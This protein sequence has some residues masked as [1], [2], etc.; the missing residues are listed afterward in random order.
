MARSHWLNALLTV[1][2]VAVYVFMLAPVLVVI[3]LAFNEAEYG[4]FPITGLTLRWF[5]ELWRDAAI[6]EALKTS[7][8]LGAGAA[9]LSTILGTAAAYAIA[10]F[11]FP[12]RALVQVF[13]T[14]PLLV[15]HLILGVGLLLAFRM[16]GLPRSFIL[17][18]AGHVALTLP[19]VVLTT[20]HR[21][22]KIPIAV[23]EAAMTLGASRLKTF[24]QITLPLAAPAIISG[25]LLA[26]ITSFDEVT[27][28]LF[29]RPSG[30][31]TVP[32]Q[33]MA[34]LQYSI[35]QRLNALGAVMTALS[36]G[37]PLALVLLF[38]ALPGSGRAS[39]KE[40]DQ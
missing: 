17:L 21:F 23:E 13:L 9:V 29:W 34:M 14:L 30:I 28:T 20:L 4:T 3:V 2:T 32:T 24:F 16:L 8:A 33:V 31:E 39:A 10:R 38:Q 36:A 11:T 27:A 22:Q 26:F 37:L 19:F 35:D 15:P 12:G 40:N 7:L 6:V 18:L 25:A 1:L 5:S